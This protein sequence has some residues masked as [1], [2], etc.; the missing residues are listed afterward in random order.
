MKLI[1]RFWKKKRN[2]NNSKFLEG[3]KIKEWNK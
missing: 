1:F 2:T 3:I